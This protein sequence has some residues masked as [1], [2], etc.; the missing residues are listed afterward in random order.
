MLSVI[1]ISKSEKNQKLIYNEEKFIFEKY[2]K[3]KKFHFFPK[4]SS[5]NRIFQ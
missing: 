5:K 3:T 1:F 4:K 2:S